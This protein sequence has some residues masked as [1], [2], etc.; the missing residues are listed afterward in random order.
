MESV[1]GGIEQYTA[2]ALDG[3]TAQ[4]GSSS[5]DGDCQIQGE[6]GFAAFGLAAD[7]PDGFFGPQF[8][9]QPA[10]LLGSFGETPGRLDWKLGHRRRIGALVWPVAGTAQISKNSVSSI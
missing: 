4:A 2:R 8:L 9:D 7:D 5:G 1:F 3:K 10:L 6:E